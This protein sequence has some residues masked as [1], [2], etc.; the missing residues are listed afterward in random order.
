M[1]VSLRNWPYGRRRWPPPSGC[2][3]RA[4][5]VPF[6]ARYRKEVTGSLDDGQLR[7]LEERLGVPARARPAPRR[8]CWPPSRSRASSPTSCR[9]ALLAADTKS[10]VED[11]YLPYKPKRRTKAQIAREAGLEPLADRLLADPTL[12][13]ED[14]AA[15]FLGEEV[16]RRRRRARRGAAHPHR[17]RGRGRRTRRR[18][19]RQVLDRRVAA[20]RA[21]VR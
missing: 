16:R 13:P 18:R 11:I 5:T 10:R 1:P 15:A 14:A 7:T 9:A 17:T 6:I 19:P 3:T 2:S 12:V 4:S 8:R 20:D 21:L